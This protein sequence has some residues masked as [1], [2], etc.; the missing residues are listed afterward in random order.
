[1]AGHNLS[2][3]PNSSLTFTEDEPM[4][5]GSED[6]IEY[7]LNLKKVSQIFL[8]ENDFNL[9]LEPSV[10]D[11]TPEEF[12][13]YMEKKSQEAKT[14]INKFK[15]RKIEINFRTL[16]SN[17]YINKV[18]GK[19]IFIF[20]FPTNKEKKT[21]GIDGCRVF[22]TLMI[23]FGCKEGLLV[24]KN[25]LTSPCK[26][27]IFSSNLEPQN[28][29]NIYNIIHYTD[30]EFIPVCEHSFVPKILKIYRGKEEI[31]QFKK[32]NDLTDTSK[33]PKMMKED[34]LVKFYRGNVGDI[35]KLKRTMIND[36]NILSSQIVYRVVVQ[37]RIKQNKT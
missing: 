36:K 9:G 37:S 12:L 32:D 16:M 35:F 2:R 17:T 10:E 18:S 13:E 3:K 30:D 29:P 26:E 6:D 1:M 11:F 34:Q 21:L 33:F 22:T 19:K 5:I 31:E 25:K 14:M 15:N 23:E 7:N 27:K 8:R 28:D 20:F 24:S 4:I